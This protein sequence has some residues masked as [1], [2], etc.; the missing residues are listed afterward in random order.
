MEG[1]DANLLTHLE[2]KVK[3]GYRDKKI[4]LTTLD[5]LFLDN[6]HVF[7][8]LGVLY[9]VS[10]AKQIGMRPKFIDQNRNRFTPKMLKEFDI[11]LT[12]EF[13]LQEIDQYQHFDLIGFPA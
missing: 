10:V 11:F 4:L 1:R 7:P 3:N 8:Y 5:S 6:Q 13:S 12:D 2:E 9:L